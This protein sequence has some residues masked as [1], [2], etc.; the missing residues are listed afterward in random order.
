MYPYL[1]IGISS[2]KILVW[3]EVLYC[4]FW[5]LRKASVD[6]DRCNNECRLCLLCP[7]YIGKVWVECGKRVHLLRCWQ[8]QRIVL[9]IF[10]HC[11][12]IL[13]QS[14]HIILTTIFKIVNPVWHYHQPIQCLPSVFI[15]IVGYID[16][17][18]VSYVQ[19]KISNNEFIRL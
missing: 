4:T 19:S 3:N 1:A 18:K 15:L 7:L 5:W 6:R 9:S 11:C 17:W 8:L 13:V 12:S 16:E 14:F 10:R 2:Q